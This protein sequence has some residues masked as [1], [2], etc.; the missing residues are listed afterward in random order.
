MVYFDLSL[1]SVTL[2]YLLMQEVEVQENC[3]RNCQRS[4]GL[5]CQEPAV[6]YHYKCTSIDGETL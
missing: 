3:H 2:L 4:E 1:S 5:H 6:R